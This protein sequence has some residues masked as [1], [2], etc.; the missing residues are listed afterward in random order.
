MNAYSYSFDTLQDPFDK[1]QCLIITSKVKIF[2][3]FCF[4]IIKDLHPTFPMTP[5]S[6]RYRL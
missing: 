5:I 3:N 4:I 6:T 1:V 2:W